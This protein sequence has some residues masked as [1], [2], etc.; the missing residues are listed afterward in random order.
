M[1]E[2]ALE[3]APAEAWRA[4]AARAAR[5]SSGQDQ[6]EVLAIGGLCAARTGDAAR[7]RALW[8]EALDLCATVPTVLEEQLRSWLLA[9][10]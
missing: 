6:V 4:L 5:V 3:D 1:L 7:A 2:L 9:G 10:P 8:R